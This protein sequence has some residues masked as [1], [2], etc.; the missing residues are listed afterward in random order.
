[1]N[2]PDYRP[3]DLV[4]KLVST[5][6]KAGTVSMVESLRPPNIRVDNWG[7]QLQGW[8]ARGSGFWRA[9]SFRKVDSLH[10]ALT[11]LLT[12][13]QPAPAQVPA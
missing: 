4:V 1:M 10:T 3:G 8:P 11:A 9:D 6:M 12:E 2:A 5:R 13:T 7:V